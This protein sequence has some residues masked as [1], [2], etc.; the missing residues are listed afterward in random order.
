[1]KR[2]WCSEDFGGQEGVP[3]MMK[4]LENETVG[5]EQMVEVEMGEG[6]KG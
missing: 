1:M 2:K 3:Q 4:L 6:V 5:E